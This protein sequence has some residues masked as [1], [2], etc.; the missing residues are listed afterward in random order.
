MKDAFGGWLKLGAGVPDWNPILG[1]V[2]AR[3]SVAHGLGKLTRM[4][5]AKRNATTSKLGHSN[6]K[7]TASDTIELDDATLTRAAKECRTFIEAMDLGVPLRVSGR[8]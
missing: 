2:E 7:I 5:L 4:Q 6:I 8:P 3:N 1:F